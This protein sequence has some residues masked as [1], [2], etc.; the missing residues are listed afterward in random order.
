MALK[1][2][3]FYYS[4]HLYKNNG[5]ETFTDVTEQ[6]GVKTFS[7][8]LSATIGDFFNDGYPDIY[9]A[10]DYDFGDDLFVNKGNGTITHGQSTSSHTHTIN[11]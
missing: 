9:V 11:G 5:N 4:S 3:N 2:P 8:G 7:F 10:N 6:A 1:Q